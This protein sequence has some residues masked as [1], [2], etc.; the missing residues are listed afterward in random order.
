[1]QNQLF[2][3][4]GVNLITEDI[5][6]IYHQSQSTGDKDS[7]NQFKNYFKYGEMYSKYIEI[8]FIL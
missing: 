4:T 5:M 8:Q 6:S 1:M 7:V 2:C 3:A